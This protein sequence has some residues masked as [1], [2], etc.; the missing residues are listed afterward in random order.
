MSQSWIMLSIHFIPSFPS[1]LPVPNKKVSLLSYGISALLPLWWKDTVA[2]VP[3]GRSVL[4]SFPEDLRLLCTSASSASYFLGIKTQFSWPLQGNSGS[5]NG[6][7]ELSAKAATGTE[8]SVGNKQLSMYTSI[9][10]LT[11]YLEG[12][13]DLQT[14]KRNKYLFVG[15]IFEGP[16]LTVSK[17]TFLLLQATWKWDVKEI[18]LP[19]PAQTHQIH[20]LQTLTWPATHTLCS[21]QIRYLPRQSHA[22]SRL[23]KS[24]FWRKVLTSLP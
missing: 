5:T 9:T 20:A 3:A 22:E 6:D 10:I 2:K 1:K 12:T 11:K 7:L 14:G 15:L 17:P 18:E 19:I 8:E 13:G 23:S 4:M 24:S 21:E 16:A